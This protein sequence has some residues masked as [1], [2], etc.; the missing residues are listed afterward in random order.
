[1]YLFGLIIAIWAFRKSLKRGYLLLA[2]YFALCTFSLVAMPSINRMINT[3]RTPSRSEQVN[4]KI[5]QAV[6]DAVERVIEEEGCP[7]SAEPINLCLPF[8]PLILV[9]GVWLIAKKEKSPNQR[10]HSIADSVG[11]E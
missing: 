4:A 10:T 8:G 2:V 9:L 5:D 11:S 3:H 1:V 7:P 6:Q